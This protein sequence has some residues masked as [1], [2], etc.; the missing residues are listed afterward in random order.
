[1]EG[2]LNKFPDCLMTFIKGGQVVLLGAAIL[3]MHSACSEAS[4][5]NRYAKLQ[6]GES[7][8]SRTERSAT[9]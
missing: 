7:S 3:S 6:I 4:H 1:M 2:F 5:L 9:T 8:M